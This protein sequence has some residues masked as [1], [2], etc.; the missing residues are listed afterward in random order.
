MKKETSCE[1]GGQGSRGT[2]KTNVDLAEAGRKL[3]K[4]KAEAAWNR[5]RDS[6]PCYL[7]AC[8]WQCSF[9]EDSVVQGG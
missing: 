8:P 4:E 9:W 6:D 2:Q 7:F 5:L 1:S 3:E